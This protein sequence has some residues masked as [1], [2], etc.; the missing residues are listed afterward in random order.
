MLERNG[1]SVLP[2][3]RWWSNIDHFMIST[4]TQQSTQSYSDM[5]IDLDDKNVVL[6]EISTYLWHWNNKST[7]KRSKILGMAYWTV[8]KES[9]RHT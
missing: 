8:K 9:Y 1:L 4:K 2:D 3:A 6:S 5:Y 7:G